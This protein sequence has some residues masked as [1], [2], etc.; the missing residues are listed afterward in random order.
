MT[1]LDGCAAGG[2]PA[3][4]RLSVAGRRLLEVLEAFEP[5]LYDD[6]GDKPTIGYGHLVTAAE[7]AAGT[8]ARG[9]TR[10]EAA[11][12]L[13]RDV[14]RFE[15]C[16]R[17]RVA[18]GLEQHQF[19]ALVCLVFNIGEPRFVESTVLLRVNDG[20]DVLVPEAWR[21]WKFITKDGEKVVSNGLVKR[22]NAELALW[23]GD[24]ARALEIARS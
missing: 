14:E 18:R 23:A 13:T 17:R 9:L 11:Q 12:L 10:E 22:R 1:R 5:K 19:D 7:L 20:A 2:A 8:F 3:E 21:R 15:S 6:Q 16:V 24:L 4:Q